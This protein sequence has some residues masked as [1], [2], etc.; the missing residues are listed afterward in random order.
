MGI[1]EG[2]GAVARVTH[3]G[4]TEAYGRPN[5]RRNRR[6]G[7][8]QDGRDG[9]PPRPPEWSALRGQ[10]YAAARLPQRSQKRLPASKGAL[11]WPHV[12]ATSRALQS[13]Q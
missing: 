1:H 8:V 9:I 12:P 5:L 11:H 2:A 3:P 10:P 4:G 6:S 13:E 7:G